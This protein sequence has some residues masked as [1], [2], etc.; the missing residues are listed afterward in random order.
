MVPSN[1]ETRGPG[2]VLHLCPS[3][4][5]A[6]HVR[7]AAE[8]RELHLLRGAEADRLGREGGN[9]E[10]RIRGHPFYGIGGGG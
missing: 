7:A 8:R 6:G 9:S 1:F 10:Q 5:R 4:L 2:R 3:D